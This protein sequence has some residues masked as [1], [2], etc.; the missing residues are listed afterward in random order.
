MINKIAYLA[1]ADDRE[2]KNRS[3]SILNDFFGEVSYEFQ[4]DFSGIIFV[5]SGGSEQNA[6]ELTKAFRNITLLCHRKSNSYA[7]TIEIA[8]YLR[9]N[10]K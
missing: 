5:A 7:A 3:I 8:A 1:Y 9:E 6:V 4:N 2:L 10:G